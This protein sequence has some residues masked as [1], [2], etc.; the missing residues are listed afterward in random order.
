MNDI[1]SI[2]LDSTS[3]VDENGKVYE[4]HKKIGKGGQG[5]VFLV[6]GGRYAI[7]VLRLNS[8]LKKEKF[9]NQLTFVKRLD[10]KDLPIARPISLLKAP[11]TGYVMAFASGMESIASLVSP[12]KENSVTEWYLQTGGLKRRLLILKK[13]AKALKLLH[14]KSLAFVDLSHN[15]IFISANPS[16]HEIFFIDTDNIRETSK[17]IDQILYTPGYAA[18][19]ILN[20]KSG[21]NT[22]TDAYSFAVLAFQLLTLIHP[23]TG[24]DYVSDGEPELE[25][26]ALLGKVP[27]VED[28]SE[29]NKS[30]KGIPREIV[31]SSNLKDLFERTF[32]Q[33]TIHNPQKR[34]SVSEWYEKISSAFDFVIQCPDCNSSYFFNQKECPFC[35]FGRPQLVNVQIFR[36]EPEELVNTIRIKKGYVSTNEKFAIQ[37]NVKFPITARQAYCSLEEKESICEIEFKDGKIMIIPTPHNPIYISEFNNSN[38]FQEV[39]KKIAIPI[40]EEKEKE[41]VL[42]FDSPDKSH[43]VLRFRR[44]Q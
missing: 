12:P 31:L 30:T 44:I 2:N 35:D 16:Y 34:P 25:E 29:Q 6:E 27:W 32:G 28:S 36:W 4:I 3:I 21:V 1:H 26:K 42:R 43:R 8:E 11:N 37:E 22:L 17:N 38:S 33:A 14:S 40:S 19:E 18:P 9:K 13:I 39:T 24:G 41:Y 23:L 5:D 20:Q 10:L 15:N 7:K